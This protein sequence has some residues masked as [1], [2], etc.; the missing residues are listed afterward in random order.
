MLG[1]EGYGRCRKSDPERKSNAKEVTSFPNGWG[2][3]R[4]RNGELRAE[5]K[6]PL[7][8]RLDRYC[9]T[10]VS[11][12]LRRA[13]TR[14]STA[15]RNSCKVR[16]GSS[17]KLHWNRTL[18]RLSPVHAYRD[19]ISLRTSTALAYRS[20]ATSCLNLE[21]KATYSFAITVFFKFFIQVTFP[22]SLPLAL[23]TMLVVS[24]KNDSF[25]E[26]GKSNLISSSVTVALVESY[27]KR[28]RGSVYFSETIP[29]LLP[30]LVSNT[31][32]Q[33]GYI[34]R[35]VYEALLVTTRGWLTAPFT[36]L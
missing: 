35:R 14:S 23:V 29:S 20:S 31:F 15:V 28:A 16:R 4:Q 6:G 32:R 10:S 12:V 36:R 34:F 7:S 26:H 25:L 17:N 8:F 5:Y 9:L 30:N 22:V 19:A 18:S 2:G 11:T 21:V 1:S 24:K 13:A 3:R 27:Y 33:Q